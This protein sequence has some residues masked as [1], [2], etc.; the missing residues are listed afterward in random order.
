[1]KGILLHFDTP[2]GTVVDS[3]NIYRMLLKYKQKYAV[4][5]FGYVDGLCAS[6]GMYISS[7]TDRMYCGH[8]G[9]VGSV[10]VIFGPFFNIYDAITKIGVQG[11]TLTAGLDKD[12]MNPIRPWK[13]DEDE[14]LKKVMAHFYQQFVDI[15]TAARPRLSRTKLVDEYGAKIFDGPTAMEL[16]YVDMANSDYETALTDLMKEAKIDSAKPYQ[17][18]ELQPKVNIWTE[19]MKGRSPILSGK[20]KHELKIG[21]DSYTIQDRFAYLYQP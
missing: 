19:L 2:G 16:G 20:L 4:P 15:V 17:I 1:V 14:V 9:I 3:D 13:P 8:G 10:G 11:K 7:A 12:M 5:V 6:G 18:V 21:P